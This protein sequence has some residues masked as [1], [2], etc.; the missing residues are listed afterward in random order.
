MKINQFSNKLVKAGRIAGEQEKRDVAAAK[1]DV[2]HKLVKQ[3]SSIAQM[4]VPKALH[5]LYGLPMRD[6]TRKQN[7][8]SKFK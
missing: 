4:R 7:E 1:R 3:Y 8:Q 2:G 5:S 6:K